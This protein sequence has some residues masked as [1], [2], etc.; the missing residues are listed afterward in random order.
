MY[1]V[2]KYIKPKREDWDNGCGA[3]ERADL[4]AFRCERTRS[5]AGQ[6]VR[7]RLMGRAKQGE[8]EG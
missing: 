5:A 8:G 7:E 4:E 2:A 1:D 3:T 6:L